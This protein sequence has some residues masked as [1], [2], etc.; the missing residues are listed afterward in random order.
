MQQLVEAPGVAAADK[1]GVG[2]IDGIDRI[3][4]VVNADGL[5]PEALG[6]IIG[7]GIPVA[8]DHRVGDEQN[9]LDRFAGQQAL[10]PVTGPAEQSRKFVGFTIAKQKQF[11]QIGPQKV[12]A[13]EGGPP[14]PLRGRMARAGMLPL[15]ARRFCDRRAHSTAMDELWMD[16]SMTNGGLMS[17]GQLACLRQ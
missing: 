15:L 7:A 2:L 9:A 6:E 16:N 10:H 12:K 17:R 8:A 14:D 1:D 13:E 11:H 3:I 5:D 4:E